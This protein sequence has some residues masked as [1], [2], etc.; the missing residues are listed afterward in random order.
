MYWFDVQKHQSPHFHARY[1]GKEAVYDLGGRPIEGSLGLRAD[2]LIQE[3]A[4][5]RQ[6]DLQSAWTL[7]FTG[8]ELPWIH[9]L[10]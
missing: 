4:S 10:L 1:S 7:A 8:K 6:A 9:P 5:E 2:R 3:W